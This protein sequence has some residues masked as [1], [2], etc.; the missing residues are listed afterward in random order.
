M[1]EVA[2]HLLE[3]VAR[4]GKLTRESL[5]PCLRRAAYLRLDLL[6]DQLLRVERTACF[7]E[8]L[9]RLLLRLGEGHSRSRKSRHAP[10]RI[11]ERLAQHLGSRLD[12]AEARFRE[13][14]CGLSRTVEDG[15]TLADFV[16]NVLEG[17]EEV[18]TDLDQ[19]IV[20]TGQ[21][22]L[23]PRERV[24]ML[25]RDVRDLT[26]GLEDGVRLSR[27]LLPLCEL[28]KADLRAD[29]DSGEGADRDEGCLPQSTAER[30]RLLTSSPQG[31]LDA[32]RITDDLDFEA[33]S[34]WSSPPPVR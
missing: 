21:R 30:G 28:V 27:Y 23:R 32:S 4:L 33:P 31:R 12:R 29:P 16:T 3:S 22:R 13:I 2:R 7:D 20:D 6:Q 26:R 5:P 24:D 10:H 15:V 14:E 8:P 11:V 18:L 25:G 9:D 34:Q 17:E 19:L 1:C